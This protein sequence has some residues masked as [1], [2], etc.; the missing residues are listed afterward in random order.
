MTSCLNAY[1]QFRLNNLILFFLYSNIYFS[2][3]SV[4]WVKTLA[5]LSFLSGLV[6]IGL[7]SWRMDQLSSS[8]RDG[9]CSYSIVIAQVDFCT[10]SIKEKNCEFYSN[11][12]FI[13][14]VTKLLLAVFSSLTVS[15]PLFS[16]LQSSKTIEIT[17]PIRTSLTCVNFKDP[18][19]LVIILF[20]I[21][22]YSTAFYFSI[23]NSN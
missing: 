3:P 13:P 17:F 16:T 19:L 20:C 8:F 14:Q 23:I 10:F 7:Y 4:N 12:L 1:H 22:I 5:V 15:W 21:N 2:R 18:L 9:K 11:S 6:M